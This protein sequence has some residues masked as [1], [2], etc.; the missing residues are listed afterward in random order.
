VAKKS[1]IDQRLIVKRFSCIEYAEIDFRPITLFVGPQ[2]SGKSLLCK[3]TFFCQQPFDLAVRALQEGLTYARFCE[4]LASDFLEWFPP[5]AWGANR[6]EIQL[7]SGEFNIEIRRRSGRGG[8]KDD[9][10]VDFSE[11]FRA[12]Y[13]ELYEGLQEEL[14]TSRKSPRAAG[15]AFA[16][17]WSFRRD[18]QLLFLRKFSSGWTE[19]Q[20]YV[21]AGRAFFTT[22]GKAVA[23]FDQS[24]MFDPITR[25]FG[26]EF[27][28]YREDLSYGWMYPPYLRKEGRADSLLRDDKLTSIFGGSVIQEREELFV[29]A[30]DGRIIPFFALSSGQQELL[31]LWLSIREYGNSL[32]LND[33]KSGK[34]CLFIEE[35]EA[36]LFPSAQSEIVEVF[37][38][39]VRID[40]P[41]ASIVL[42]S[43]S[44]YILAKANNLIKAGKLGFR[45][46]SD[47]QR[48]VE[49]VIQKKYWILPEE[50]AAYHIGFGKSRDIIDED[51][52][53][54]AE[55]IDEISEDILNEFE[56]LLD[57]EFP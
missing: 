49:D 2:G 37:A 13:I 47:R 43:H 3:L 17:S 32:L 46:R 20:T 57:I 27:I 4:R 1:T 33:K 53:I 23:A 56:R 19:S 50:I 42:T 28:A 30:K 15:A 24:R 31:P 26:R 48:L 52:L 45:K 22:V 18:I 7:I 51:G 35:P 8:V 36:H 29:R 10:A 14:K 9:V 34:F 54:S 5:S 55:Y 25:M 11:S 41:P 39:L 21:P 44:P 6:F 40:S 38:N 16:H 12:I